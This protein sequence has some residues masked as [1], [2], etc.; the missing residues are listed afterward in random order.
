MCILGLKREGLLEEKVSQCFSP[1]CLQF[2]KIV[3]MQKM[4]SDEIDNLF[5]L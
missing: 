5:V 4:L 2:E 1:L 3:S